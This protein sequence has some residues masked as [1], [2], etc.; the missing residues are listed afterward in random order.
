MACRRYSVGAVLLE[1]YRLR[2]TLNQLINTDCLDV[3]MK[4]PDYIYIKYSIY[5][6]S[7]A[8]RRHQ[9]QVDRNWVNVLVQPLGKW[10]KSIKHSV[11]WRLLEVA[12]T[13]DRHDRLK[14]VHQLARIDHLKDWDYQHLAQ[15]CDA[16][17]AVALA[18]HESDARWFV[19]P[20][21]RGAVRDPL[22]LIAELRD[23]LERL[24]AGPPCVP[25]YRAH[26]LG[27]WA[28]VRDFV[29]D[30][31]EPRRLQP[32]ARCRITQPEFVFLTQC[33]NVVLHVTRDVQRARELLAAGF[34][35]TL[36]EVHKLFARNVEMQFL[37][38][39]VMANL[40]LAGGR[41]VDDAFATGWVGVLAQM[42]RNPDLRVQVTAAKALTNL[43]ADDFNGFGY[44]ARV[45]PL[46]PKFCSRQRPAVDVVFVHGLL[47]GVFVTWRQKDRE[48]PQLGLYGKNAIFHSKSAEENLD[49]SVAEVYNS[50]TE[51]QKRLCPS[52]VVRSS[53]DDQRPIGVQP[54]GTE[55]SDRRDASRIK[56][57]RF[58]WTGTGLECVYLLTNQCS[59]FFFR[60]DSDAPERAE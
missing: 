37:L 30:A 31:H 10:W 39:R 45:Y 50:R 52:H 38:A 59:I 40:S 44:T 24:P 34:L 13:G 41:V 48:E 54:N 11:A 49:H 21:A 43:D 3:D 9:Q 12:K 6:E 15:L 57:S 55:E 23:H 42:A 35:Q 51:R 27:K 20:R 53:G 36:M 28:L 2:R 7:M 56:S 4:R 47:G 33:L 26:V 60:R 46:Y 14:A 25:H 17:T 8:E 18:R 58:H 32:L 19:R 29:E 16:R 1:Y 5:R 22:S